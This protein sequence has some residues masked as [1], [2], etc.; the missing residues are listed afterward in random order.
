VKRRARIFD[1]AETGELAESAGCFAV[2][3]RG[4][5]PRNLNAIVA[6]LIL[7]LTVILSV[8]SGVF[9]AYW[10][11]NALLRALGDQRQEPAPVLVEHHASGD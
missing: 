4:K 7:F 6:S 1:P 11:M 10:S 9:M 3:P 8:S 5:G 2:T